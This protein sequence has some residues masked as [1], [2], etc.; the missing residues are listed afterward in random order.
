MYTENANDVDVLLKLVQ[1]FQD[2]M[3]QESYTDARPEEAKRRRMLKH[4]GRKLAQREAG[5]FLL[6][7][8]GM[9]P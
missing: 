3:P 1:Q 9:M 8:M 6:H 4:E 5:G 7:V 2:W